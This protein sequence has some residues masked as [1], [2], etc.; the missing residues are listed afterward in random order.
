MA[1]LE[2]IHDNIALKYLQR[3]FNVSSMV[4]CK[5]DGTEDLVEKSE[6]HGTALDVDYSLVCC[7]SVKN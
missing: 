6:E 7:T 2:R 4:S 5:V 3:S 1:R